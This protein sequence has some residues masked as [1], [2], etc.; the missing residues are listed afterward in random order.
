MHD[1]QHR[2]LDLGE[3]MGGKGVAQGLHHLSANLDYLAGAVANDQ[4]D[5]AMADSELFL[6]VVVQVGHWSQSLRSHLPL[7]CQDAQ[8]TAL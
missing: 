6:E 3:G 8:L 7:F 5:V 4:V 1:L 2:C